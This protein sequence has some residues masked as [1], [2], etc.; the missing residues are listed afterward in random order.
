MYYITNTVLLLL[1]L[2]FLPPI[3]LGSTVLINRTNLVSD[4]NYNDTNGQTNDLLLLLD[5]I[6]VETIGKA[7][8]S[9]DKKCKDLMEERTPTSA[10]TGQ[11][12]ET[13][14]VAAAVSDQIRI[15]ST[16]VYG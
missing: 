9:L 4:A 15:P 8:I 13:A 14:A 2:V 11:Q 6:V 1:L 12:S 3:G 5:G 16:A 10:C 7:D